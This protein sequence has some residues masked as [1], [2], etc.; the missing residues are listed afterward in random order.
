M[1]FFEFI[2]KFPTE[3]KI[4]EYFIKIR[5]QNLKCNHCG[6]DKIYNYSDEKRKKFFRCGICNRDFSIFKGTIFEHSSTDLRKWFYAIHLFLN[7][8]KGISA[9]QLQREISVTYKT[10]WRMLHKIREAMGNKN[11]DDD[12]FMNSIIEIDE[13]YLGGKAEN[14]HMSER[15]KAKGK[16]KKD[17]VLGMLERMKEVRAF[18]LNDTKTMTIYSKILEN[19]A[20][21]SKIITDEHRAYYGL[22]NRYHHVAVN[23]SKGEYKKDNNSHTNT[24]EGFWAI[25]K[26]GIYGV[27]HSISSKH[28]QNY[29]NE[30]CFRYNERNN[31]MVFDKLV[32]QCVLV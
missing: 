6:N 31:T 27:Y 13:A 23:H 11:N 14:K 32:K 17:I 8:K 12:D 28:V 29:I 26:R 4:I 7:G 2:K 20:E 5:Y 24:I 16:F 9:L 15:V 19:I 18:K 22:H 30:F 21:N 3:N 25:L 10:A 1:N